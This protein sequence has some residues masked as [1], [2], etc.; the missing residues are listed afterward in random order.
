MG[1]GASLD[2]GINSNRAKLWGVRFT[3]ITDCYGLRFILTYEGPNPVILRLQMRLMLWAMDLYHRNA[4]FLVTADYLSRL[5]A[6]LCFDEMTRQYLNKTTN[7]RKLYPPVTGPMRPENMPNYRAPRVRSKM[8]A[9]D[10]VLAEPAAAVDTAI[11]PLL[12]AID[13]NGS[14]GHEFCLQVVPILTGYLSEEE[15]DSKM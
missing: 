5:G 15:Q 9:K 1:E 8:S 4:K 2:W 12:A 7:L 11:A 13:L 6:D 10:P 3:A 14:G